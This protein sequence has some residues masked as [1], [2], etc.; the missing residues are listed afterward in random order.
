MERVIILQALGLGVRKQNK[1]TRL[2]LV[3]N[4]KGRKPI[5]ICQCYFKGRKPQVVASYNCQMET[6]TCWNWIN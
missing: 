1:T 4:Y 6:V 5:Q 2:Y 3:I